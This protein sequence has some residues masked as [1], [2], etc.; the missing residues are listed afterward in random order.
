MSFTQQFKALFTFIIFFVRLRCYKTFCCILYLPI[1]STPVCESNVVLYDDVFFL[2]FYLDLV[3][4]ETTFSFVEKK[5]FSDY[6]I[7]CAPC[8]MYIRYMFYNI[9]RTLTTGKENFFSKVVIKI[10]GVLL[11]HKRIR[12][13]K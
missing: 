3:E 10:V 5:I 7:I 1:Y 12:E 4:W 6:S 11:N 13:K 8:R 2:M 9:E